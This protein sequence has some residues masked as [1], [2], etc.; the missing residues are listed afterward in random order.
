YE[1]HADWN[2][3]ARARDAVAIPVVANGDIREPDDLRRC[4]EVTGCDR[5]MIGRGS[6]ARPELFAV[7]AGLQDEWWPP[8][9]RLALLATFGRQ[10][11]RAGIPEPSVVGKVK[12]WWRYMAEADATVAAAFQRGKLETSWSALSAVLERSRS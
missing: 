5:F 4:A 12:G 11:L 1:G 6:L 7:L 3:I 10:C 9:H 8:H 2:A